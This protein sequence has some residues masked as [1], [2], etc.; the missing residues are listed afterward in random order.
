MPTR[1]IASGNVFKDLG[2]DAVEAQHL[3][4]RSDLMMELSR[5]IDDRRLT[6]SQA[7]N[8]LGV[9]QPRISDLKRGKIDRFS[10]DGLVEMLGHA[11]VRVNVTTS[12]K[13]RAP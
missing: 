4:M 7:A 13:H 12:R 10:I 9:T 11:G 1:R 8:L 6:Q 5:L 3:K 2:F